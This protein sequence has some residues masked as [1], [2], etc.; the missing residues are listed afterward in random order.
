MLSGFLRRNVNLA[1]SSGNNSNPVVSR[2]PTLVRSNSEETLIDGDNSELVSLF[3]ANSEETLG[4]A[5]IKILGNP[6]SSYNQ[7]K[8]VPV[9]TGFLLQ[10][11][12]IFESADSFKLHVSDPNKVNPVLH[13]SPTWGSIFKKNAPYITLYTFEPQKTVFCQVYFKV[14]SNWIS[15]YRLNFTDDGIDDVILLNNNSYDPTV[16][17]EYNDT[18]FRITGIT[19]TTSTFGG[20]G[21]IKMFVMNPTSELLSN[22]MTVDESMKPQ[23]RSKLSDLIDKRDRQSIH[24]LIENDRPAVGLPL[25]TFIDVSEK[26]L[27][28]YVKSGVI[29]M[30]TN[31]D[32]RF[33]KLICSI[34]LVLREQ[35]IRKFR[36]NNKPSYVQNSG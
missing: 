9:I 4:V 18:K 22:D 14:I 27:A 35:E 5:N 21:L 1:R 23:L 7:V 28:K 2:P 12:S 26:M 31:N 24:K 32:P 3:T 8:E 16:D 20:N 29:K 25:A 13:I 17:F 19:G 6:L 11:T 15:Y 36:G 34:L 10:G 33:E 30:F